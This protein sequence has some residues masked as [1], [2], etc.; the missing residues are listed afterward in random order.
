M[1]KKNLLVVFG[2]LFSAS[3]LAAGL[4]F[5]NSSGLDLGHY[6]DVQCGTSVT[7]AQSSGKLNISVVGGAFT[8]ALTGDGGDAIVGFL[9]NTVTATTTSATI[10]QC[11]S[12]FIS[13]AG[14]VVVTLPEA[15]TA[16]GCRYTFLGANANDLDI[17]PADGTDT[18]GITNSVTGGTGA[19]ISPSAGD[20]IR[21]TDTGAS[22][23]IQAVSADLWVAVGVGNLAVTDVN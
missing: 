20:A 15:S 6:S 16:I 19:S 12:T 18:I 7:C 1:S 4:K 10:A 3:A 9:N 8:G 21:I 5:F 14:A 17:N 2:L 22:V 11:G 23:T 13:G